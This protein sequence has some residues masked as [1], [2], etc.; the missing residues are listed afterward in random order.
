VGRQTLRYYE[1]RGLLERPGRSPGGHRLYPA[2]AVTV[3]RV[4]KAA[5]QL[6]FSLQEIGELLRG[7]TSVSGR[8][9]G[10]RQRV[11]GRLAEIEAHIAVLEQAAA[12]LRAAQAAGCDDLIECASLPGCPLPFPPPA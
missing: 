8:A 3:L 2:G 12:T 6:G 9:G 11:P 5:Q 10:L 1:R 4:I 7:R